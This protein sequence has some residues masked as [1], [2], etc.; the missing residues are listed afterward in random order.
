MLYRPV[1][2]TRIWFPLLSLYFGPPVPVSG[3]GSSPWI[4]RQH[5]WWT[6]VWTS[7]RSSHVCW[8]WPRSCS[9]RAASV[10]NQFSTIQRALHRSHL[11]DSLPFVI[12]WIHALDGKLCVIACSI[13]LWS[14]DLTDVIFNHSPVSFCSLAPW[15]T[16]PMNRLSKS[17]NTIIVKTQSATTVYP[18]NTKWSLKTPRWILKTLQRWSLTRILTGQNMTVLQS[19]CTKFAQKQSNNDSIS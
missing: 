16:S 13:L 9:G 1:L 8:I 2:T 17:Q 6:T 11:L 4:S 10:V 5:L 15:G 19:W 7:G 14:W 12:L 18:Q 3:S